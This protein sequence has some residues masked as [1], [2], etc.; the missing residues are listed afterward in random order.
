MRRGELRP[1]EHPHGLDD[2]AVE[3]IDHHRR[4]AHR[5]EPA[6]RAARHQRHRREGA[7]EADHHDREP[8]LE[9]DLVVD[10]D[11]VVARVVPEQRGLRPG[12][13]VDR[14]DADADE[15]RHRGEADPHV[16][17]VLQVAGLDVQA[18]HEERQQAEEPGDHQ[19]L[20][21]PQA[22]EQAHDHRQRQ[23]EPVQLE[24]RGD[25]APHEQHDEVPH[26]PVRL[27]P[28]RPRHVLVD[29]VAAVVEQ[30]RLEEQIGDGQRVEQAL[31]PAAVPREG[32]GEVA[33]DE[34]ERRDVPEVDEVVDPVAALGRLDQADRVPDDDQGDEHH[35]DVVE[36]RITGRRGHARNRTSLGWS[37]GIPAEATAR[38]G[39]RR[40]AARARR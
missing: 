24:D 13:G 32:L 15:Q 31:H 25:Q 5:G 27:E 21:V 29:D 17:E 8:G 34:D 11:L 2:E 23:E 3:E 19:R 9:D 10:R 7:H 36:P 4:G 30:R 1:P 16:V 40:D 33:A 38:G 22:T 6:E 37:H 12:V 35:L 26:G 14:H 39:V 28:Q 20:G 18:E